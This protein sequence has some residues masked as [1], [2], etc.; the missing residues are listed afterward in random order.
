MR[1]DEIANVLRQIADY[2]ELN[3]HNPYRVRAYRRAARSVTKVSRSITDL[4]NEEIDLTVIPY[5][6]KSIAAQIKAIIKSGTIPFYLLQKK[7][8]K[9]PYRDELKNIEGLGR[10]RIQILHKL[11]IHTQEELLSFIESGELRLVKGFNKKLEQ[12]LLVSL[13]NPKPY[14]RL[15]KWRLTEFIV[16]TLVKHIKNLIGVK[17][18]ICA[19][20]YRRRVEVIGDIKILVTTDEIANKKQIID[21][22]ISLDEIK[23]L[24][25][26]KDTIAVVILHSG[27]QVTL[28]MIDIENLGIELILATGSNAHLGAIKEVASTKHYELN[29]FGLKRD[30]QIIQCK[31][32]EDFYQHLSMR[33]IPAE[34]RE[35][36]GEIVRSLENKLPNLI[37]L[38][39][40]KG[41]LHVHT[42]ETDGT[43]PLIIMVRAAM[44]K[45]Y[46]YVAITDHSYR[47]R[48]TNGLDERRLRQ[49]IDM[50]DELNED[51][52]NFVVLKSIEVD[53]LEDGSLD[54]SDDI[55][56]ELDLCVCS[57]HSRFDLSSDR[58]TERI[59]RAMDNP[60]FTILGHP[61]GR[62]LLYR[63]PYQID[64]ERILYA[65]KERN[66]FMELNAQPSRFDLKDRYCHI[67]KEIGVKLAI[68]TDA[69]SIDEFNYMQFGIDQGRRGWLEAKD[70]I[71]TRNLTDFKKLI[72]RH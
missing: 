6:G 13:A 51:L 68:S 9:K 27:M 28:K 56:K 57:I 34:L 64:L 69:H 20:D 71:N 70:V 72:K 30:N 48:I 5:V 52:K 32:E 23:E 39:E 7:I 10:K 46:E 53:I 24:I 55:L 47:L 18:V 59:L 63:K 25:S 36:Q 1:N 12:K 60:H 50:I 38:K 61:T 37:T 22:F 11:N 43:E 49:Q 19:G 35:N 15:F 26:V 3:A 54:L 8:G 66:C 67:A 41:D 29:E 31:T 33:Y 40:I 2:L 16:S 62:L 21:Q 14:I 44:A 65:A 17:D 58:Q 4:I 42:E 45:G